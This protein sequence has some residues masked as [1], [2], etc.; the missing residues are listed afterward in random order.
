MLDRSRRSILITVLL[1][2]GVASVVTAAAA[3]EL[4]LGALGSAGGTFAGPSPS[5]KAGA[6][7][8]G[9]F[10]LDGDGGFDLAVGAWLDSPHG[11]AL[12]GTLF[13]RR[14]G[15]SAGALIDLAAPDP[16]VVT[17]LGGAPGDALGVSVAAGF[18][19]DG[20]GI[21]DLAVG[22]FRADPLG[23][24]DAGLVA[25][26]LGRSTLPSAIDLATPPPGVVLLFGREAGGGFGTRL[27]SAGDVDGDGRG[28]LLIGEPFSSPLG[29]AGAGTAW[30]VLGRAAPPAVIDTAA[31]NPGVVAFLGAVA[32]DRLGEALAGRLVR[33][34]LP[35]V[36]LGAPFADPL[37][38]NDAGRV[39]V[40]PLSAAPPPVVDLAIPVPGVL[41]VFGKTAGD[42]TGTSLADGGDRDGDGD[43]EL[44][45]GSMRA[46][47]G[48]IVHAGRVDV[49]PVSSA[50]SPLDLSSPGAATLSVFGAGAGAQLGDSV[51]GGFDGD[52][53]GLVDLLLGERGFDDGAAQD[54]GAAVFVPRPAGVAA[55]VDLAT[56]PSG[57]RVFVGAAALD[58]AGY[59]VSVAG[60]VDGT[61]FPDVL[62]GAI[63]AGPGATP[64]TGGAYVVFDGV[65][66]T[67]LG[68]TLA[69][70]AATGGVV[71]LSIAS[72]V[73][74]AGNVALV[75]AAAA[76]SYPPLE[77]S[78]FRYGL[79]LDPASL[80]LLGPH[81]M[82][83]LGALVLSYSFPPIPALQGAT[84][85]LQALVD[86]AG[87]GAFSNPAAVEFP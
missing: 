70:S 55:T 85:P 18:D 32:G 42:Q 60:D 78:P 38:R 13:V 72:A 64:K 73:G 16:A 77:V 10:D 56:P 29:R 63:N 43:S 40:V 48:A 53:D 49:V 27:A 82:P 37:G 80:V 17:I 41:H 61:G 68:A 71:T 6:A 52:G 2:P 83:T 79:A 9:G 23:R 87:R 24:T 11:R 22:A 59:A 1:G 44:V 84:A 67:T 81:P 34:G 36:A 21:D 33:N 7:V 28:D 47:H 65:T 39:V 62:I 5:S 8:E 46:P 19:F 76:T 58:R 75:L 50:P 74:G 35:A 3:D 30:L 20:D 54:A 15:A 4:D 66:P 26:V 45:V 86:A 12:A 57:A 69:G 51:A 25:I 31:P 14:G